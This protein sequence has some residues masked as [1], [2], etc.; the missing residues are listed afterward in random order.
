MAEWSSCPALPPLRRIRPHAG[1]GRS[2]AVAV[3]GRHRELYSPGALFSWPELQAMAADG[4]LTQLYQR[5]Y[6]PPGTRA[7]PQ[8]RARAAALRRAAGDPAAGGGG[9]DDRGLDLRLRRGTGPA[10]AAGGRQPADFQPAVHPR[11]HLPRGPAGAVRRREPG[12]ADGVQ[13]AADG[14]GHRPARGRGAGRAGPRGH[15]WPA[16]SWTCGCGCSGSPW[17]PPPGSRTRRR[18]WRS[19]PPCEPARP[20]ELD[21]AGRASCAAGCRWCGRRRRRRR[22][23]GRR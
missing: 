16:R 9:Q 8:L 13:P 21:R 22:S 19:S 10:G 20:R 18:P 11:L 1:A 2:G 14:A 3:R 23:G 4:V 7:T 15:S 17:R 12:R 5:G 6:L